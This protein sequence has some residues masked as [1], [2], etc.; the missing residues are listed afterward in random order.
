MRG[1][2]HYL[3][4]D[5]PA[6]PP[7]VIIWPGQRCTTVGGEELAEQMSLGVRTWGNSADGGTG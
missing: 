2:G 7:N 3:V 6:S 5:D 1:P 4:A